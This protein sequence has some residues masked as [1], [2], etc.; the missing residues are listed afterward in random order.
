MFSAEGKIMNTPDITITLKRSSIKIT[1]NYG[2]D[3]WTVHHE[4]ELIQDVYTEIMNQAVDATSTLFRTYSPYPRLDVLEEASKEW[5]F[6][7]S[8][9]NKLR[10][11]L[12]SQ[13]NAKNN[14]IY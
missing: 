14:R 3:Q 1:Y 10:S 4:D 2:R 8:G 13:K 11:W 12:A 6:K 7:I 5:G 9:M